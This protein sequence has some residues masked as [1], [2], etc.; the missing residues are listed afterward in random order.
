M[1]QSQIIADLFCKQTIISKSNQVI[2]KRYITECQGVIVSHHNGCLNLQCQTEFFPVYAVN[3]VDGRDGLR[4]T[5]STDRLVVGAVDNYCDVG[6][7][8]YFFRLVEEAIAN[9]NLDD[10][11]KLVRLKRVNGFRHQLTEWWSKPGLYLSDGV[12]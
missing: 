2:L 12:G 11:T 5:S 10:F 9:I 7:F 8:G 3:S 4:Q 6:Y 1:H